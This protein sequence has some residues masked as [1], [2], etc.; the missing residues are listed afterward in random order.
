VKAVLPTGVV[1]C[2]TSTRNE[3]SLACD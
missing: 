3:Q 1:N 2:S